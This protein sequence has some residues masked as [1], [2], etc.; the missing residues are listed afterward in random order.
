MLV[1]FMIGTVTVYVNPDQVQYLMNKDGKSTAIC[2]WGC[3]EQIIVNG[4]IDDVAKKLEGI[5]KF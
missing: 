4:K 3:N 1:Q 5:V 2:F